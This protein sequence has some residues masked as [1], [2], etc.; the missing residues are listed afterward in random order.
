MLA[1]KLTVYTAV[2]VQNTN[3]AYSRTHH[4]FTLRIIQTILIYTY[5]VVSRKQSHL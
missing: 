1:Y 4:L 2:A 3:I 5:L